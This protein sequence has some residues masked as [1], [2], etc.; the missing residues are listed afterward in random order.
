SN[1]ARWA[2]TL[3]FDPVQNDDPAR[4][5]LAAQGVFLKPKGVLMNIRR[6]CGN[7]VIS[8]C[9]RITNGREIFSFPRFVL[10][11]VVASVKS[12]QRERKRKH[13]HKR[14]QAK[15]KAVKKNL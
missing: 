10:Q 15:Q 7:E 1:K 13:W 11:G 5:C 6:R 12:R 4:R 8:K 2:D 9:K 3:E 14:Q